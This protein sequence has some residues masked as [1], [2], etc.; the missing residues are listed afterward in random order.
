VGG[1]A[2]T[3][4]GTGVSGGVSLKFKRAAV[5]PNMVWLEKI[6]CNYVLDLQ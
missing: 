1:W 2:D 3:S 6:T 4:G 5:A